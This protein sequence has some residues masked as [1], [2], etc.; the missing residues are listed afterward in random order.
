[1]PNGRDTVHYYTLARDSR[2]LQHKPDFD[3]LVIDY[4]LARDSRELQR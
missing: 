2:E 4:T 3:M 1:M